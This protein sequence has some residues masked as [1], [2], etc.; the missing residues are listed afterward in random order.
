MSEKLHEIIKDEPKYR[1]KQIQE[2]IFKQFI[3][4]WNEATVLPKELRGTLTKRYPLEIKQKVIST[5]D[6]RTVKAAIVLSDQAVVETVLMRHAD[7]RN[8]VCVSSQVGCALKCKFCATGKLGF[9]RNLTTQEIVNQVLLFARMLKEENDRVSNVV[10]MGMGEPLLNYENVMD[11]IHE[12]NDPHGLNIG[13]RHLSIST[14]G[15]IPGIKKL[16]ADPQDVNLALSLHAPNDE[17]R[18]EIMPIA[19]KYSLEEIF[20]TLKDYSASKNR[21]LMFEY[22]MLENV[23][24]SEELAEELAQLLLKHL[25]KKIF[26]VNLIRYNATG[27]FSPS[28]PETIKRFQSVLLDHGIDAIQRY[29]FG[30]EINAACGQLANQIMK[31]TSLTNQIG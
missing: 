3:T 24:D 14:S 7:G 21:R 26:M 25:P 4:D 11:A 10:F 2:L 28:S 8:T 5:L 12:F 1:R 15:I 16:T 9:T 6:K 23:N 30:G 13:I 18:Q 29:H 22:L 31:I 27:T 20:E 17:K 19:E